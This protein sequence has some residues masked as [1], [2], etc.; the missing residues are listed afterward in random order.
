M[1]DIFKLLI[2]Y[3]IL[4]ISAALLFSCNSVKQVI[5]DKRKLDQVAEVVIRSGYCANDTLI[6]RKSDTSYVHDTTYVKETKTEVI[7]DTVYLSEQNYKTIVKRIYIRDTIKNMVIDNAQV[8]ALK[9][10]I[11]VLNNR[12]AEEK[13]KSKK[14]FKYLFVLITVISLYILYKFKKFFI[15]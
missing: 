15:K 5:K 10:D 2:L 13:D 11:Y 9:G 4:L 7:N 6:I 8:N 14:R 1:K 3:I 12:L